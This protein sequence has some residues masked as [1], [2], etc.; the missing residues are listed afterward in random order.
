MIIVF[1]LPT[2]EEK[3][4]TRIRRFTLEDVSNVMES[5]H[6][7]ELYGSMGETVNLTIPRS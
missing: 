1:H 3:F 4:Q 2:E 5:N 6:T 7:R